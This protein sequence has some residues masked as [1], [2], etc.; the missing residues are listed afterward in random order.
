MQMS[1]EVSI[2][3]LGECYKQNLCAS[4]AVLPRKATIVYKQICPPRQMTELS[5]QV[6]C[7]AC[8]YSEPLQIESTTRRNAIEAHNTCKV[9]MNTLKAIIDHNIN[10]DMS[11][12]HEIAYARNT[13]N[14]LKE[15]IEKL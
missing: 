1:I 7:V 15:L 3:C 10:D 8:G 4:S 6:K 2:I 9:L 11:L 13:A 14:T 12:G 5:L